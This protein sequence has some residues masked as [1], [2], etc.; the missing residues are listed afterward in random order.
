MLRVAELQSKR[1]DEHKMRRHRG[2]REKTEEAA[3]DCTAGPR[4]LVEGVAA[5]VLIPA[6]EDEALVRSLVWLA[7]AKL[8]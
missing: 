8:L 4:S 7:R 3:A 5:T 2:Q 1:P 6:H